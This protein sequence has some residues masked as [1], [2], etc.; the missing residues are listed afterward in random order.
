[1]AVA[2][3]EQTPEGIA[4]L[5][6]G[7]AA[8]RVTG[9]ATLMPFFF[10]LLADAEGKAN[11]LDRGWSISPRPSGWCPRLRSA[12]APVEAPKVTPDGR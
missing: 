12:T 4:L 5:Q 9:A 8:Y 1:M 6:A 11:E 2:R 3:G 7:V 10:T